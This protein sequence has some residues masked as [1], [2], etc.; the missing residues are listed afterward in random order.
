MTHR[1]VIEWLSRRLSS[2]TV[3][4]AKYTRMNWNGRWKR[5]Y[6]IFI[7]GKRAQLLCRAMLPWLRV[8]R[9]QAMLVSEFPCRGAYNGPGIRIP[10][11]VLRRRGELRAAMTLLNHRGPESPTLDGVEWR[12]MPR[13]IA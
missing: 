10:E 5:Q 11:D 3:K 9:S 8:K 1:G 4:T 2:G 12:G 6:S 13:V 7:S